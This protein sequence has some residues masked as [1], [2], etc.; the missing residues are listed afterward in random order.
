MCA[1]YTG[2]G[3]RSPHL[4]MHI[5]LTRKRHALHCSCLDSQKGFYPCF[6]KVAC[7][8]ALN[9][10]K[11][12]WR[13]EAIV[14]EGLILLLGNVWWWSEWAKLFD[15]KWF[16]F[17]L[18]ARICQFFVKPPKLC[19][20]SAKNAN[21]IAVTCFCAGNHPDLYWVGNHLQNSNSCLQW[22]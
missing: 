16:P 8:L 17:A 6:L 9:T 2:L 20:M 22:C 18:N 7:L 14:L 21:I 4:L 5:C 3:E 12:K 15:K 10:G 11:K 1:T 13:G 19:N